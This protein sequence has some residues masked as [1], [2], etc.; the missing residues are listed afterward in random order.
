MRLQKLCGAILAAACCLAS[1]AVWAAPI[2]SIRSSVNPARVRLV[3]DSREQIAYKAEK[4]GNKLIIELPESSSKKQQ[5]AVKDPFIKKVQLEP[6]GKKASRLTV[7]MAKDCQYK[8]YQLAGPDRL[9]ID[10]YR[11]NI[12]KQSRQLAKGV[13]Y[14]YLQDEMNGRQIQGYLLSVDK[15]AAYELR[16]FSAAGTYNGRG[17]VSK[18]AAQQG[19][20]A[21]VN[22]S[23]F[24]SDGWVIGIVKDRGRIFAMD[25]SP[26]SGYV[27]DGRE[28]KII[29]DL[30]YTGKVKLP[31]GKTLTIKGMNRA[32]IAEDLVL[33]NEYYAPST[34]TN[35]YGREVKIKNGR[36]IAVSTAGNMSIE[37]GT[38][39]IS[40]HG[41]NA[42][43]LA[44]LRT[45]D[46]LTVTETL[47]AAEADE[48]ETV[49]GGGPLLL[50]N[51]QVKVRSKEENIAADIAKGRAPRTA[52]GLK[53]DGTLLVLVV[54]G[55]S[56][57]SA[58]LTLT[59]LAQYL[60]RLGARDAVN[61]DGG[62]SSVMVV[63]KNIVNHP[64]DGRERA[65]SIGAGLFLRG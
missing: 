27:S 14:T 33:F 16:P 25:A 52:V 18:M 57:S 32:R 8:I 23:Y 9:V 2:D 58:G 37:P 29:K 54:D 63:G 21:A 41:A 51:G 64:S 12:I 1:A 15:K 11:I 7:T 19:M 61:F 39:V 13:T 42:A 34:K 5:P 3:L 62:G 45:G 43:A 4:D 26:H 65:V 35:Q 60:L 10:I 59:E 28:K 20:L 36:V 55:R 44:A 30:A 22:A 31:D 6:D 17:Y 48:A 49:M 38:M 40:G 56:A 53:K 46:K 50:E 47:G 24:D